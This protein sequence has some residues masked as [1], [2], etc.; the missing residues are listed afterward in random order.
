ARAVFEGAGD[1]DG[2]GVEVDQAP[3]QAE[4][5]A[6]TC[7][8]AEGD[9][10]HGRELGV[11]LVSDLEREVGLRGA[12]SV[13]GLVSGGGR[14]NVIADG[15]EDEAFFHGVGEGALEARVRLADGGV[16][17]SVRWA[18]R[19]V[20]VRAGHR[21]APVSASDVLRL[22]GVEAVL[23]EQGDEVAV[24]LGLVGSLSRGLEGVAVNV[25][26]PFAQPGLHGVAGSG[27]ADASTD[28]VLAFLF[29]LALGLAVEHAASAFAVL[30]AFVE[31]GYPAAVAATA[32]RLSDHRRGPPASDA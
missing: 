30:P 20:A 32:V 2:G 25:G 10:E 7:A 28:G 13:A 8:H 31:N 19:A 24:D 4:V 3:R 27:G 21:E 22:E 26:H 23:A 5:F 16:G 9:I 1:G 15:L 14:V 6:G 12:E 11:G 17:E 29:G 18:V